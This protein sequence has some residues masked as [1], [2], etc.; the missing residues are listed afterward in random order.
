MDKPRK[1]GTFKPG[2]SGNP[3]GRPKIPQ[4]IKDA[5][6]LT[7]TRFV[8]LVNKYLNM[9][10]EEL[11]LA[12][13]DAKTTTLE[14]IVLKVIQQAIARGDQIRLTFILDRLIGKVPTIVDLDVNPATIETIKDFQSKTT[15]ELLAIL[16]GIT[17]DSES[18]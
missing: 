14:L 7:Q 8:I 15:E 6:K 9:N 11:G 12:A 17:L 13:Q 16:K 3:S 2:S 5:Q 10:R 4:E 1:P 18:E